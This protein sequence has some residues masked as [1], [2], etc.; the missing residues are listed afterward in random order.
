MNRNKRK[1]AITTEQVTANS[2]SHLATS[3]EAVGAR[4][5]NAIG[6]SDAGE[7]LGW[8]CD[9]LDRL[10]HEAGDIGDEV[11]ADEREAAAL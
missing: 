9:E 8:C 11:R 1:P 7:V 2:I 5:R 10:G 4:L 3:I 6:K